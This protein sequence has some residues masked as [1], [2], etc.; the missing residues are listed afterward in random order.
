MAL[1]HANSF[2]KCVSTDT[3]REVARCY[4]DV[5]EVHRP[6]YGGEQNPTADWMR[7]VRALRRPV[8]SI[9]DHT[10]SRRKSMILEGV[11]LEPIN[12]YIEKWRSLGG[13]ALGVLV[14]V[15]D[16]NKHMALL[17]RRGYDKQVSNFERIREVQEEMCRLASAADWLQLEQADTADM[18]HII[19]S[20][21]KKEEVST[22]GGG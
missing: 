11:A 9:L 10:L 19:N 16:E 18:I 22:R 20:H 4:S 3:I 5:P 14:K 8:E 21:F 17:R 15:R 13:A 1:A 7:S 12:A 6:S 2:K